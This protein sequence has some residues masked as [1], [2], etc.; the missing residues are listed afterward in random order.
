MDEDVLPE[1]CAMV[2]CSAVATGKGRFWIYL[3]GPI[4]RYFRAAAK[5]ISCLS[6]KSTKNLLYGHVL[7]LNI[8]PEFRANL[9]LV[10]IRFI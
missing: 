5:L 4:E 2:L 9:G 8:V 10:M 1:T 3:Q 7:G 6:P